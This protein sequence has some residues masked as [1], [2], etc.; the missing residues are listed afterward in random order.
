MGGGGMNN[1]KGYVSGGGVVGQRVRSPREISVVTA[2]P[3][4]G[5]T[6]LKSQ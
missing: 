1:I 3:V 5:N 6:G 4:L 2:P